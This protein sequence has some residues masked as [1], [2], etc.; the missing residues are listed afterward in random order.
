MKVLYSAK[1]LHTVPYGR[2]DP[3]NRRRTGGSWRGM[4][5]PA[6]A[7][8]SPGHLDRGDGV[9]STAV[10]IAPHGDRG[11]QDFGEQPCLLEGRELRHRPGEGETSR[12]RAVRVR[13]ALFPP[14]P[15][16][17]PTRFRRLRHDRRTLRI[18]PTMLA[19]APG[20]GFRPTVLAGIPVRSPLG[21][22]E[23]ADAGL[24]SSP[25]RQG[26]LLDRH[27]PSGQKG[28]CLRLRPGLLPFPRPFPPP[29]SRPRIRYGDRLRPPP[30]HGGA[31]S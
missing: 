21:A 11:A 27:L 29:G 15:D 30:G 23:V 25:R 1:A 8:R 20:G 3:S 9:L 26:R 7:P 18:A 10:R 19:C 4:P 16:S 2:R 31:S 24:P 12:G 17:R 14:V 6:A 13:S 5:G 28:G 22:Y